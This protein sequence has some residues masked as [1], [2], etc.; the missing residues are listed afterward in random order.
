MRRILA[1]LVAGIAVLGAPAAQAQPV[2]TPRIINGAP[3]AAG[4]MPYLVALID[5]SRM[6]QLGT[7][8][9]QFC[10]GAL[11]TPTKV[12][13]AA[14][15]VVD[16]STRLITSPGEILVLT[17]QS[18][19]SP[20]TAPI[21][22]ASIAV[23]PKYD[24]DTSS[25]DIAVLTLAS[26]LEG[27]P[28]IDPLTPAEVAGYLV[29]GSPVRAGGW[30]N[31]T[32]LTGGKAYPDFFRIANLVLFPD[33]MCG[34]HGTYVVNGVAFRGF[35]ASDADPDTMLCA[36]AADTN[37][38]IIDSCQGDSG[39]PLVSATGG[40]ERLIGVVSWGDQCA[41]KYPGVYTRVAAM[42]DFLLKQGAIEMDPP[43]V[44]PSISLGTLSGA[45]RVSFTDPAPT[46]AMTEF[47]ARATDP[48]GNSVECTA[49]P[50]PDGLAP[51]C[52]INGLTNGTT[53][54][55]T[56]VGSNVAG[57][58]P[59]SSAVIGTPAPV[60]TP[61]EITKVAV[62]K[63]GVVGFIVAPSKRGG[64]TVTKDVVRC[65]PISGGKTRA[66]QVEK[67]VAVVAKLRPVV[68]SCVHRM[69]NAAGTGE[70]SPR[71]VL[72]RR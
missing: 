6:I 44:A 58:S 8:Q 63:N 42:Y 21:A 35:G 13:T 19:K 70:S 32:T 18:L 1:L 11:V 5:T 29:S 56:A 51:H 34:S 2:I 28:T 52:T 14:H 45:L 53:Y 54:S 27:L 9:A 15:C 38:R 37:G 31:T 3:A 12:V 57:A 41:S 66:D 7:Y 36:G 39:G 22:V 62:Q 17:G 59:E 49:I 48:L 46:S 24:I 16:Q 47:T 72:A 20:T 10:G 64:S 33:D 4:D 65:T 55:V 23:H 69:T 50:H 30:G 43:P 60:P 40:P 61:G 68:Y 67:R 26:P 25:S 71:A